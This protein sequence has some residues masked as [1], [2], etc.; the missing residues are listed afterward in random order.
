VNT[1]YTTATSSGTISTSVVL[2]TTV[3]NAVAPLTPGGYALEFNDQNGGIAIVG[4]TVTTPTLTASPSS[5]PAGTSVVLTG[6]GYSKIAAAPGV[7]GSGCVGTADCT[8]NKYGDGFWNGFQF[9][10]VSGGSTTA[11]PTQLS[12]NQI[13]GNGN[14]NGTVELSGKTG[15]ATL[16]KPG[17]KNLNVNDTWG[18]EGIAAFTYTA[19]SVAL[20]ASSVTQGQ[21]LTVTVAGAGP[22]SGGS[23]NALTANLVLQTAPG[24]QVVTPAVTTTPAAVFASPGG[25]AVFVLNVPSPIASGSYVVQVTDVFGNQG[26]ASVTIGATLTSA[27]G[28]YVGGIFTSSNSNTAPSGATANLGVELVGNGYPVGNVNT[29]AGTVTFSSNLASA[30]T[31]LAC[32]TTVAGC[33]TATGLSF[34]ENSATGSFTLDANFNPQSL[35]Q[36]TYSVTVTVG[37]VTQTVGFSAE[38]QPFITSV[39]HPSGP[40]NI[41]AQTT[42]APVGSTIDVL[43]SNS[44]TTG[45]APTVTFDG[46]TINALGAPSPAAVWPATNLIASPIQVVPQYGA[47]LHNLCVVYTGSGVV[48]NQFTIVSN[49]VVAFAP[50]SGIA[51]TVITIIGSGFALGAAHTPFATLGGASVAITPGVAPGISAAGLLEGTFTVPNNLP[52]TYTLLVQDGSTAPVNTATATFTVLSQTPPLTLTPTS[53]P[54]TS[55]I[56]ATGSG[57]TPGNALTESINGSATIAVNYGLTVVTPAGTIPLLGFHTTNLAYVAGAQ[58]I[59]VSDGV[60]A[61]SATFTVVPEVY[62]SSSAGKVGALIQVTGDGFPQDTALTMSLNGTALGWVGFKNG[63]A[64]ASFSSTGDPSAASWGQILVGA[65]AAFQVPNVKN[66][67]YIL[68]VS[69]SG[70]PAATIKFVVQPASFVDV[71]SA[72]ANGV[73]ITQGATGQVVFLNIL[74]F[75]P[76]A[77]ATI[78]YNSLPAGSVVLTASGNAPAPVAYQIPLTTTPGT[79]TFTV[80]DGTYTASTNFTVVAASITAVPS[81]VLST[82]PLNIKGQGFV[83]QGLG[84]TLTNSAGNFVAGTLLTLKISPNSTVT[85]TSGT[86]ADVVHGTYTLT[87][88]DAFHTASV[89]LTVSPNILITDTFTGSTTQYSGVKGDTIGV[90]GTGFTANSALT[91][92]YGQTLS[93]LQQ[94]QPSGASGTPTDAFG[95][96]PGGGTYNAGDIFFV[97]PVWIDPGSSVVKIVDASGFSATYNFTV[98]NPYIVMN[99]TSGVGGAT[100]QISGGYFHAGDNI[101]I[102]ADGSPLNTI[103]SYNNLIVSGADQFSAFFVVP[104]GLAAGTHTIT[105][106]DTDNNTQTTTFTALAGQQGV[107]INT[108]KIAVAPQQTVVAGYKGANATYT[109]TLNV[110]VTG[111]AVVVIHNAASQTVDVFTGTF[112]MAA[113]ASSP[114]YVAFY[115]PLPSQTYSATVYVVTP[116]GAVISPQSTVTLSL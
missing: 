91:V 103:P 70:A 76:S 49:T 90:W 23:P 104:S 50:S 25:A 74:Y 44:V 93:T 108:L 84:W 59:G 107:G 109:N 72:Q 80:S 14:Y 85:T 67:T 94:V 8:G 106:R 102:Q 73:V 37:A 22:G 68:S 10:T 58:K 54:L 19:I 101:L 29:Q 42:S 21:A 111:I 31:A 34:T 100:I 60:V 57:F 116:Q 32:G 63:S 6:S 64:V 20:G 38:P 62:L 96:L 15:L 11:T 98:Y 77:T 82:G 83:L 40:S 87:L 71:L 2:G 86:M 41:A 113:G 51:G 53:G 9:Q 48:C 97:V 33:H 16:I 28:T 61:G 78:T 24:T 12:N 95:N 46:T 30:P 13:P 89:T 47:G 99:P 79:Y 27:L 17:T 66:G 65:N 114:V 1:V 5:G 92:W 81:S 55:V 3:T 110:A 112:T 69:G 36:G 35:A 39:V 45:S 43:L 115:P 56:Q 105:V 4:Y 18:N 88:Y 26:N 52:G 7:F 75:T